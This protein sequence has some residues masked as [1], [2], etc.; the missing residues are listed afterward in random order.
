MKK[1]GTLSKIG[2][3][4]IDNQ[5]FKWAKM[6]IVP[7]PFEESPKRVPR[8]TQGRRA[9]PY[10]ALGEELNAGEGF[11]TALGEELNAGEGFATAL[12]EELREKEEPGEG[13]I[14]CGG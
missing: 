14:G 4:E 3:S 10:T 6:T 7:R 9:E 2:E 1:E 11:A 8:G 5:W 12:G 13:L